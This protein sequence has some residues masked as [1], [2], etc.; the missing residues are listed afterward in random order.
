MAHVTLHSL[1]SD[2]V[3]VVAQIQNVLRCML[4]KLYKLELRALCVSKVCFY[5]LFGNGIGGLKINRYE[6]VTKTN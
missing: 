5:A 6:G 4:I 1:A 2:E 3:H